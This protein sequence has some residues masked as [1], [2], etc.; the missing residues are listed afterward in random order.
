VIWAC[1]TNHAPPTVTV[2]Q[3]KVISVRRPFNFR[4]PIPVGLPTVSALL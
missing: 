4:R 1:V 3:T 2:A